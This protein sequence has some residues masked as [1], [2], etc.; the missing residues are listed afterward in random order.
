MKDPTITLSYRVSMEDKE[1]WTVEKITDSVAYH[2]GQ[3]LD[4]KTVKDLCEIG[5]W[6]VTIVR[7]KR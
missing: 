3:S 7:P 5:I 6:K 1:Y 2:P 4:K